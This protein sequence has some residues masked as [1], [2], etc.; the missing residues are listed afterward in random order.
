MTPY[1]MQSPMSTDVSPSHSIPE[2][3]LTLRPPPPSFPACIM[4]FHASQD[5]QQSSQHWKH[6]LV[7]SFQL[8]HLGLVVVAVIETQS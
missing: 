7:G 3:T 2:E 6:H 5:K 8:I 1:A 4:Q